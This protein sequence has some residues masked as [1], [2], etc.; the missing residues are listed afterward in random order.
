MKCA[1]CGRDNR[2]QAGFCAWCGERLETPAVEDGA[3]ATSAPSSVEPSE[4]LPSEAAPASATEQAKAVIPAPD[5]SA[6]D[7]ERQVPATAESTVASDKDDSGAVDGQDAAAD[8]PA[9]VGGPLGSGSILADRYEIVERVQASPDTNEYRAIDRKLCPLCGYE[10]NAPG[11]GYCAKCGASIESPAMVTIVE[12]LR[13]PPEQYDVQFSADDRDYY[14]ARDELPQPRMASTE[15]GAAL[16]I[17]WGQATDAGKQ[18]DH[19]EDYL[20][21]RLYTQSSGDLLGLFIVADGLGGQDS[22]EVAS[23]L[24]TQTIWELLRESIWKPYLSGE[25]LTAQTIEAQLASAVLM[26]NNKVRTERLTVGS[27][28]S[29]TLTLALVV[30]R[31][32]YIGNVGDSRTYVWNSDGLSRITTDHSL[33]QR[34]VDSGKIAPADVYTHPRRNLIYQSIGDRKELTVDTF[35]HELAPDDRLLLCSDG[36]WEMVREE[37]IEEVLMSEPDPQRACSTLLRNA[38]VAGGEDNITVIIIQVAPA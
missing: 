35:R 36:L 10:E 18:R 27:E 13:L 30:G 9:R 26:A 33:V 8:T 21:A 4:V 19:N 34:L 2:P 38:N 23:R 7:A 32:A 1:S 16:H 3:A 31:T 20:D 5:Q 17:S 6:S 12:K 25:K 11:S 15:Q 14:V 37:G 22:G 28:M 24:A 29:T